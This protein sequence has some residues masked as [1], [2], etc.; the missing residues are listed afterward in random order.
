MS[1]VDFQKLKPTKY[2]EAL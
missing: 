2:L 1:Y